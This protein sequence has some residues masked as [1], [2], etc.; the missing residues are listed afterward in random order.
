MSATNGQSIFSDDAILGA[1]NVLATFTSIKGDTFDAA[2]Q[3]ILDVSQALGQD[4]QSSTIQVG[5]ALNDPIQGIT[6]LS[7]VGVSF[8]DDQKNMI[9]A[10]VEAGD[11]AGA[12]G[13]ILNELN[14][15]FGGS[16]G[17]A[18]DTYAG[19]MK[20]L[21]EQFKDVQQSVGEALLP[22]LQKL[23]NLAVQYLVPAVDSI[24][25]ALVN[26]VDSIDWV[27]FE[28]LMNDVFSGI[29]DAITGVD[30]NGVFA[31][32]GDAIDWV[33][34]TAYALQDGFNS[35]IAAIMV[36][37][38][39]FWGVVGPVWAQFTKVLGDA[40]TQL[41][42]LGAVFQQAF[43]DIAGQSEAMAPIGEVLGGIVNAI[44][45]VVGTLV[46]VLV[47]V[48]K[49]VFPLAV[50][51]V[52][53]LIDKFM[54]LYSTINYVFS[55]QLQA[56]LSKWWTDTIN[57]ISETIENF[58]L[59]VR[60]M[61]IKI[62]IGLIGGINSMAQALKDAFGAVVGG[63]VDWLKNLLGI[64]SPSVVMAETIGKPLGMG[65]AAGIA[66]AASDVSSAMRTTVGG[67][68]GATQ[69]TVQ[70]F[71]L[72]ATYNTAQSQSDLMSDVR[73]MQILAG[74]V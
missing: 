62:M 65:I 28:S 53:G 69:Q 35:A 57:K 3:S 48:I 68:I 40:W 17:A 10:M 2:T 32:I 22:L 39:A 42:P 73:A 24:A 33:M 51:Y 38:E 54:S 41:Q 71:Y 1:E 11:V 72:S 44:L 13:V 26:W 56:D 23:G 66:T 16:A 6:A 45:N 64:H 58:V 59:T 9:K 7:R 12:Q 4:L 67:A 34:T 5:K 19:Q 18:V 61:G 60:G 46:Q 29:S 47:P 31:Q 8:T 74:G 49:F 55:G 70:N 50:D 36:Q 27:G 20:V 43:G 37:V 30:W 15:E 21:S 63:A 52:K 14:K 25:Q